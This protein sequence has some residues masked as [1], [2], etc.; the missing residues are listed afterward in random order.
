MTLDFL[1][2]VA[3]NG[4]ATQKIDNYLFIASL[5]SESVGRLITIVPGP[6]VIKLEFILKLKIKCND[7][8]LA[9]QVSSSSQSLCFILSLRLYSSFITS[10]PGSRLMISNVSSLAFRT[11]VQSLGK[12]CDSTSILKALSGKLDIK[13]HSPSSLYLRTKSLPAL[14]GGGGGWG[15]GGRGRWGQG[16]WTPMKITKR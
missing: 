5:N 4:E 3:N 10:G 8:L 15:Q 14:Q 11:H 1:N 6:E 9:A 12:P 13:R 7:W 16:V 2:D